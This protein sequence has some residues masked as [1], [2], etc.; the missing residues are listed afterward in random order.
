VAKLSSRDKKRVGAVLFLMATMVGIILFVAGS[1]Y[2]IPALINALVLVHL[3]FLLD[4]KVIKP[5]LSKD[6]EAPAVNPSTAE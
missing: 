4:V 3:G 1:G 5:A 2:S 6:D